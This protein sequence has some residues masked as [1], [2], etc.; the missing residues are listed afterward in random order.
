LGLNYENGWTGD[1]DYAR[2][3]EWYERAAEKNLPRA[4]AKLAN[5]YREGLGVPADAD[6]AIQY[7]AQAATL[8]YKAPAP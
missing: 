7:D 3:R 8:G 5:L 2:A 6:R 1:V 4:Y